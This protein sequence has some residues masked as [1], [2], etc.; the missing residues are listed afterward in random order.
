M[1]ILCD[2]TSFFH[3]FSR[4]SR[5]E[6]TGEGFNQR[7]IPNSWRSAPKKLSRRSGPILPSQA[8]TSRT[9]RKTTPT[10]FS[11][12]LHSASYILVTLSQNRWMCLII[13]RQVCKCSLCKVSSMIY[14]ALPRPPQ[15]KSSGHHALWRMGHTSTLT[16]ATEFTGLQRIFSGSFLCSQGDPNNK[17]DAILCYN[18]LEN[19]LKK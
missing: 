2:H 17:A 15:P 3:I 6:Q 9:N 10:I 19:P 5:A 13:D 14:G 4:A 8:G 12:S 18:V 1:Y 16:E 11:I 7:G